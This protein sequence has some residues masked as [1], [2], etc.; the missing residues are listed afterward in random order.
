MI[1]CHNCEALNC[2]QEEYSARPMPIPPRY[3]DNLQSK[4]INV[5]KGILPPTL[6]MILETSLSS[7]SAYN[8][9]NSAAR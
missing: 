8:L 9:N 7:S 4:L 2:P 3:I 1:R 6:K 5:K